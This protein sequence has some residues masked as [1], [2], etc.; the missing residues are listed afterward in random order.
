MMSPTLWHSS[1]RYVPCSSNQAND[2]SY[3]VIQAYDVFHDLPIKQMMSLTIS[4]KHM[5]CSMF[6]Q[7][8]KWRLLLC[9][10]SICCL[11]QYVYEAYAAPYNL[12]TKHMLSPTV[13]IPNTC[14]L[15]Q[16]LHKAYSVSYSLYNKHMLS[17]T[18]CIPSIFCLLQSVY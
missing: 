1:I 7:S 3:Y 15:L 12:Y 16:S 6:F 2:V 5:L 8:S 18:V 11:L 17:P 13:C 4:F 9:H 14:C 10:S